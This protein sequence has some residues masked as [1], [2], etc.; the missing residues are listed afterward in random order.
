MPEEVVGEDPTNGHEVGRQVRV[1]N[2]RGPQ[3]PLVLRRLGGR[4]QLRREHQPGSGY[5]LARRPNLLP[6]PDR[7]QHRR[8]QGA[9]GVGEPV[10][11]QLGGDDGGKVRVEDSDRSEAGVAARRRSV[12]EICRAMVGSSG[13]RWIRSNGTSRAVRSR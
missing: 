5:R 2:L 12:R 6:R 10:A 8:S 7:R 13:P 11:S 9:R 1:Q 4:R 3:H